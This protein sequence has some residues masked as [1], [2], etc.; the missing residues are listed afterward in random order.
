MKT[1]QPY[2]PFAIILLIAYLCIGFIPNLQAV[3]KIAP[4]W[5]S[6]NVLNVIALTFIF[7][8]RSFYLKSIHQKFRST[9]TLLYGGFILWAAFSYFYALN[10]TE[11]IVNISRQFGVFIMYLSMGIL[12]YPLKNK[13]KYFSWIITA[14]LT[15]EMYAVINEAMQMLAANG[16][17]SAGALKGVTANRNITAFSLAIKIPFVYYLIYHVEKGVFKLFLSILLFGVFSG[18]LM[19]Q[20]RASFLATGFSVLS[21]I[22][23]NAI[24]YLTSEKK[25]KNKLFINIACVLIPLIVS[26][27][28]NQF[29]LKDKGGDAIARAASIGAVTTDDSITARIRYYNDV[30]THLSSNP[31]F[32]VG[33]GNWKLK[34]IEYDRLDIKGYVVPYHA[35]SDFIQLG[36]EL[37]LIGALFYLGVFLMSIVF[38]F[39][40]FRSDKE[41]LSQK[42]FVF[43]LL[44]ALG[45]YSVDASLN[46]PIARPQVLVDWALIVALI[47]FYYYDKQEIKSVKKVYSNGI[48][49][50]SIFCLVPSLYISNSVYKSL[51]GQ[52]YLLQDFNSNQYN[53]PINLVDTVVP[54]IP[55]IT[56]TTI[57]IQSVKARY[58]LNAK[59]YDRALALAEEGTKANPYLFYSELLKSQIYQAQGKLDSAKVYARKAF[60][61]L[62]NNALHASTYINLI[63]QTKDGEALEEAFELLTAKND[64]NNWKN[65]LIVANSLFPPQDS[66]LIARGQEAIEV[67]PNNAE[68]KGLARLIELGQLRIN[69]AGIYSNEGLQYF[70][71]GDYQNAAIQFTLA[72]ESNPYE[73]SYY[74]NAATSNYLIGNFDEAIEQ[75]DHV[76]DNLNP[77]NGKCEYIKA[78]IYIRM[79]DPI[80]ACPFIDIAVEKGYSQA[81]DT[82]NQ[83]CAN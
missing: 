71:S 28:I 27:F 8:Q 57:P 47:S 4:Q 36:A 26:I 45:I 56:V 75:I 40:F 65:Y 70:N 78:I 83:Y 53:V 38:S 41:D 23:L 19:I 25:I 54:D 43:M 61:G 76:I 44:I 74:E 7:Y 66:I 82:Y 50:F 35:H 17:I 42:I 77:N 37:G 58:F 69:Q 29:A 62:P 11:V 30:W 59:K 68:I 72:L 55:N 14:I 63:N 51:K 79:G 81:E 15:I 13:P 64:F 5:L 10:P 60:F 24:L 49:L 21:F 3:D 46:F 33:L 2:N 52:M 80:G 73:Y 31:I 6:M 16:R 34:S 22:V 20:S 67:F 32:G 48:I 1:L 12:I 39:K 18:L 9:I